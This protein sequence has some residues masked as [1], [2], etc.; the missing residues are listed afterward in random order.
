M[1]LENMQN[2]RNMKTLSLLWKDIAFTME[3]ESNVKLLTLNWNVIISVLVY[4]KPMHTD[5]YLHN[6]SHH[7]TSCKERVVSFFFNR[8]SSVITKKKWL[9]QRKDWNKACIKKNSKIF[10][11]NYTHSLPQSQQQMQSIDI[12]YKETKMSYWKLTACTQIL[13][14]KIHL[15]LLYTLKALC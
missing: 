4:R 10:K 11:T 13:Q 7:Q 14:I 2:N 12:Q 15:R 3:E 9:N 8:A 6:S 5:Q 1:N